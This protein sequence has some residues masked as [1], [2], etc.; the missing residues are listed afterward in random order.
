MFYSVCDSCAVVLE[1]GDDSHISPDNLDTVTTNIDNMGLVVNIGTYENSGYW[2]C[3][4]CE[5]TVIGDG[6]EYGI[7]TWA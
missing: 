3:A 5:E 2:D 1:N 7:N 6:Y 4:V